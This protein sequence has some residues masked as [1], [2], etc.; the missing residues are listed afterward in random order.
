MSET[1]YITGLKELQVR[2]QK[3]SDTMGEKTASKPVSAALRKPAVHL[4]KAVQA[5][6]RARGH[7]MTGTLVNNIVV[8]KV[9]PRRPQTITY[10]V[11][12]RSKA[13][14]YKDTKANR[15]QERVGGKYKDYG[16]LFYA[17]FSEFGTSHE[18]ATPWM[19]PA[20]E[21]TKDQ[22]PE[23]FRAELASRLESL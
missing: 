9:K 20:F 8:V 3:I 13:K 10:L 18:P 14:K 1:A 12:V 17:R 7:V 6:L 16:P 19:R 11:A 21:E 2:V 22:L 23:E 4:Q 5:H 15:R